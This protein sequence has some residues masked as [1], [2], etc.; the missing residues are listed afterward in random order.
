MRAWEA[1]VDALLREHGARLHGYAWL[2]TGERALAARL[3]NDAVAAVMG[4]RRMP[5]SRDAVLQIRTYLRQHYLRGAAP[6]ARRSERAGPLVRALDDDPL[7]SLH[8]AL[9][10]LTP[11]ERVCAVMRA[12]DG[13]SFIRIA[14]ELDLEPGKV[15]EYVASARKHMDHHADLIDWGALHDDDDISPMTVDVITHRSS[16]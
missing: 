2:L 5:G 13:M 7:T 3:V 1:R 9:L 15:R 8:Q 10:N 14:E 11:R 16:R 6:H 4:K 12:H